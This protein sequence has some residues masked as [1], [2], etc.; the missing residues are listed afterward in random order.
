MSAQHAGT[1]STPLATQRVRFSPAPSGALHLGGV[2]TALFNWLVAR[3]SGGSFILRIEDTDAARSDAGYEAA[4]AE[5][6]AWLGL[7]QDE[8]PQAGGDRGPYRQSERAAAGVW[9][10]LSL[11]FCK[12]S[13][14]PW[15]V[16]FW[17]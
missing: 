15:M 17:S 13:R 1:G 6:L 7:D 10:A 11:R 12:Y 14:A 3:H 4:I 5:D 2:R 8:G 9:R 16:N